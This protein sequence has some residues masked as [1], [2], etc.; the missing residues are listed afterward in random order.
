MLTSG[1]LAQERVANS[2]MILSRNELEKMQLPLRP[3][4]STATG[5]AATDTDADAD[6]DTDNDNATG[7]I[8]YKSLERYA[9]G[10]H[11]KASTS[12][13]VV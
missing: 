9:G 5:T 13:S 8:Q 4:E 2:K 12:C 1:R 3:T 10:F 7:G 6:T 11:P